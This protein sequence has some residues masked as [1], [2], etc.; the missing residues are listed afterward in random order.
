MKENQMKPID[1]KAQNKNEDQL[2]II[3]RKKERLL[4]NVDGINAYVILP[5]GK[6]LPELHYEVY[7][8]LWDWDFEANFKEKMDQTNKLDVIACTG[9]AVLINLGN[10]KAYAITHD[11]NKSSPMHP[12]AFLKFGYW[13]VEPKYRWKPDNKDGN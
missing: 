7:T 12:E 11:G 9:D 8:R 6:M 3:A 1:E 10:D 4:V 5:N 13:T 2:D